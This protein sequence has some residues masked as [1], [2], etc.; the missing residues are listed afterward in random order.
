VGAVRRYMGWA[1]ISSSLMQG[2]DVVTEKKHGKGKDADG[3]SL[4]PPEGD[5]ESANATPSRAPPPTEDEDKDVM[6]VDGTL[7]TPSLLSCIPT[8][9]LF[10]SITFQLQKS[11]PTG[12]TQIN[13]PQHP[14]RSSG[15]PRA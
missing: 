1:E 2:S 12:K 6:D 3:E 11:P 13:L 4:A 9:S 14:R 8:H 5:T 10:F 7:P 15:C